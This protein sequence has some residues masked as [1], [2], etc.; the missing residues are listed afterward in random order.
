RRHLADVVGQVA[1]HDPK[2]LRDRLHFLE[3]QRVPVRLDATVLQRRD[4]RGGA[5]DRRQLHGTLRLMAERVLAAVRTAPRTTEL[6]EFPMPDLPADG[7]LLR[8][9]VPALSGPH[10]KIYPK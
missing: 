6:R 1:A 5:D 7:A 4:E 8:V 10:A 9:E 2:R 3:P